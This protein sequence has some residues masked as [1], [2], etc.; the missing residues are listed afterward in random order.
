M[1]DSPGN[2]HPADDPIVH[3]RVALLEHDLRAAMAD[4]IGGLRL[5]NLSELDPNTRVQLERVR[6]ASETMAR[7][8]E[9]ELVTLQDDQDFWMNTG[10]NLH[11]HRMLHDLEMRWAGRAQEKGLG[12]KLTV[13]PN[14]PRVLSLER[15]TLD[16][17]TSN[18][19]GNAVK[20]ADSGDIQV[21]VEM[22]DAGALHIIVED[23]GP[24]FSPPA[25]EKLFVAGARPD[26]H[27][28]P[29]S[30]FGLSIAKTMID[31]LGGE[32]H[33]ANRPKKGAKVQIVLPVAVMK[34]LALA[35]DAGNALPDLSHIRVLVADDSPTNQIII[36]QMLT[37]M[38]AEFK[39]AAD[40]I[41]AM[42]WFDRENFDLALIDIEM[43]RMNGIEVLKQVR[44]QKGP[45]SRIPV[46]AITAYVQR[47]NCDAIYAAGADMIMTKPVPEI[48]AVGAMVSQVLRRH[49]QIGLPDPGRVL[50]AA[51]ASLLDRAR[52]AKLMA[53]SGKIGAVELLDRL[54][55]DLQLVERG[56]VAAVQDYDLKQIK[57]HTHVLI[58]LAGA[59]GADQL[60][61]R[62]QYLNELAH[63]EKRDEMA[64]AAVDLLSLLEVLITFIASEQARRLQ[65]EP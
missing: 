28:K 20:Y 14:V 15:V 38:G 62:A 60:T 33:I 36:G 31:S 39:V 47:S 49:G 29:G 54:I 16:R 32:I 6:A 17:A 46:I 37:T 53:I 41:E 4:V 3:G 19:L 5:I 13:A 8:I 7:L 43:P 24:G 30:G 40:G 12:F 1:G 61:V 58:S 45:Q 59:V 27:S 44:S 64:P 63:A 10:G 34:T 57:A 21:V 25:L 48:E 35:D 18:I 22:D 23:E 9:H 52:F 26:G 55:K 56:I 51:G 2:T 11:L 42:N 50:P 65:G